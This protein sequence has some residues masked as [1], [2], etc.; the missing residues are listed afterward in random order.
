MDKRDELGKAFGTKK[1]QKAIAARSI[2]AISSQ[3]GAGS[4]GPI[5]TDA[6]AEAVLDSIKDS[7]GDMPTREELQAIVDEAKPRPKANLNATVPKDVY[8][9][10][11]LIPREI[12]D[13]MDVTDWEAS[14]EKNEGI[15]TTSRFVSGRIVRFS[16]ETRKLKALRYLL[17]LIE[18]HSSLRI[19][20]TK[21]RK[22]PKRE[23]LKKKMEASEDVLNSI[24]KQFSTGGYVS[25]LISRSALLLI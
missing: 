2:N 13:G 8:K 1:T 6:V 16:E 22:L 23:D 21:G 14:V 7:V 11:T 4:D 20:K 9:I 15:T 24:R 10:K 17:A 12:L 19:L 5:P 18:F 25:S 3:R